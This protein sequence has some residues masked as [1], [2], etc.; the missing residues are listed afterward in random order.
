MRQEYIRGKQKL[1]LE[2]VFNREVQWLALE[3]SDRVCKPLDKDIVTYLMNCHVF[4]RENVNDLEKGVLVHLNH[5]Q[6][7]SPRHSE[8]SKSANVGRSKI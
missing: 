7:P 4:P 5:P 8:E 1:S 3:S 6:P 2:D